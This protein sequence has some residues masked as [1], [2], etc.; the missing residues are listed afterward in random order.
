MSDLIHFHLRHIEQHQIFE[1]TKTGYLDEVEFLFV[2]CNY[3]F[4]RHKNNLRDEL[5]KIKKDTELYSLCENNTY[6]WFPTFEESNKDVQRYKL[7]PH[8]FLGLKTVM[9]MYSTRRI[10]EGLN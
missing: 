6:F 8:A 7:S 1:H 2:I 4:N 10:G 9:D 5:D 3:D